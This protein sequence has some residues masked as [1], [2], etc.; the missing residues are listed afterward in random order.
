[1]IRTYQ[2][3]RKKAKRDYVLTKRKKVSEGGVNDKGERE[4]ASPKE[5]DSRR[6]LSKRNH[7]NTP[8]NEDIP[9]NKSAH[10]H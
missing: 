1:M 7:H 3:G 8:Q 4:G 5:K 6:K 9:K 2:L 10:L